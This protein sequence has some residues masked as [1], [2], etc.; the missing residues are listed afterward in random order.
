MNTRTLPYSLFRLGLVCFWLT[1]LLFPQTTFA[2]TYPAPCN[3]IFYV[4]ANATGANN[5]SS[6]ADAYTSLQDALAVACSGAQIWVAAGTYKPTADPS[7]NT[8]PADPRTKTFVMKNGVAI[9]GGF[10]NSGTPVMANRN[11][12]ANP[13]ILSGD[14]GNSGVDTDNSYR[15]INNTFTSG[16]PLDNTAILDGVIV[17]KGYAD[18]NFPLAL[19][20]GMWN[21]YASPKVQNCVFRNNFAVA[22]GGMFNDNSSST[23]AGCLFFNNTCTASGAGISNGGGTALVKILNCTF[24]GNTG[25]VTIAN[26]RSETSIINSIIWGNSGGIS[27]GL[28]SYS[29]VQGGFFGMNNTNVDPRFVN[30]AGG[31]FRLQ[32]YSPAIDA[33]IDTDAPTTDLTGNVRPFNATGINKADMGAYEYQS[34]Y[35][36]CA[37][38]DNTT[39]EVLNISTSVPNRLANVSVWRAC[40]LSKVRITAKGAVGGP[41]GNSE[42]VPGGAGATMIGEFILLSGQILQAVAGASG[43]RECGGGG[44]GVQISG[45]N[46]LILA[47]AGGGGTFGGSVG[48]PGQIT[49]G[50]GNGGSGNINTGGG[51]GGFYSGGGGAYRDGSFSG[52]GGGFAATGGFY[53]VSGFFGGGGFG[54]GGSFYNGAGGGGGYDGGSGT[55]Y[56]TG[57]NGGGSYNIG[58]NQNN[59]AGAN[60]AGGQVIIEYLGTATLSATVTPTELT[61]TSPSQGSISIDLTGDLNGNTSGGVE[62]AIVS[63]NSFTGTPTFADVTADP[64]NV[65]SGTGTMTGTYTVRIRLKYNPDIFVDRNYSIGPRPCNCTFYVKE[66]A[67]GANNGSSWAD[68]Y[69]SLQDALA[70]ACSGAQIWVAK[71]TYKPDQGVGYTPGN[72]SHSFSMKN[73]VAIYGG[74][75]GNEAANYDLSLRNFTTNETLLSGDIDGTPDVVTGSGSTLSITGNDGNSYH[76]ISNV[77]NQLINGVIL[78]GFTVTGGNATQTGTPNGLGFSGGGMLNRADGAGKTCNITINNCTFRGNNALATGGG[79]Y[80]KLANGGTMYLQLNKCTIKQNTAQNSGGG[81]ANSSNLDINR[82]TISENRVFSFGGGMANDNGGT[83][84]IAY[85][86]IDGN[87]SGSL[88]GGISFQSLTAG[89]IPASNITHSTISNNVSKFGAGL[90]SQGT[91]LSMTNCLVIGNTS[92]GSDPTGGAGG[93]EN[94]AYINNATATLINCSFQNNKHTSGSDPTGDDIYS[95]NFGGVQ[96]T[97]NLKNTIINGSTTTSTPNARVYTDGAIAAMGKIVSQGNNLDSDGTSGF[98]NGVNGD[99]V[100]VNPLFVSATD[101][102]LQACSPAINAGDPST[103]SAT[104]GNVDLG[105]N[106]RFY[107]NER[108]DMGAYEYQSTPPAAITPTVSSSNPTTCGGVEGSITLSGFLA[109]TIYSVTYKKNNVAISAANFTSNSSGVITLTGLGVGSYTDIVATYGVCVSNAVTATLEDPAKPSLTLGTIPAICASSTTFSIP[110]NNP[111]DSPNKYTIT[112][113]GITTVSDGDLTSPITVQL[114]GPS[115]GSLISFT[116]TV[117][118]STTTCVSNSIQGSVTVDPVSA[119]GSIAGSAT[120]CSGTNSTT[121][122]LSGQVGAIQKWQSSLSSD[123]S[124]AVDIA[125]TTTELTASNLTQTTYYRAIVKNGVCSEAIS[126][127][128]TVTVDPVSAGGSIAGSAT[129]CSGTNSTT[130]TLSGQVGAIQKWQSSLSSDFSGAVDIA[131]TTTE[132]TASNLTQTTYYRA[133]VKS[134]VCSQANST[135][136][137]VTVDPV[138][139]GGSISGSVTVCSG[140]NSTVLTLSGQVGAIQKWQSSLSSDFSGAVDISN[141]TTELTASNLTQPTYYRAIVKSGVC[142]EAFSS[143]AMVTVDPVSVGGSIAGLATV[144]SGANSTTLTLSGHVG[145][146]QKWQSSLSSDFSGALDIANTTTELIAS[147]LTQTTYYRAIVKSGVCS[148]AISMTARIQVQMKPTITLTTLQ[149]TL[150]EGN[151]QTFCDTDA[152]PINGLQFTVSGLCVVGNPVWRVQVGSNGWSA[153]SPNAPVSQLSNNQSHRYQAACDASC[154]VTYTSPIELTINYRASTPQNV[155]L[156]AD[157]VGVAVGETKEVCNIEG[158]AITFNATCGLGEI[159]LYSVDGAE[160]SSTLPVQLVDG[161]YHNYRVRCRKSDGTVSCVETE[162]GVMRLRI[163]SSSLVAPVASLNVTSGCGSPVSFSGTANCGALTTIWYNALTNVALSSLPNQTPTETS[164]YYARCQAGGGC[165]SEKSNVV[166]YTVI[167]LGVAPAVTVSQEIVC[168][169]TTVR[170]SANCPAGS[171]TFWNTGVTASSF[172]VSFSNVTKQSYWA[173]CLFEGGCQ[174]AESVRKDVYW[175]AF[176]V[177]LINIGESKSA[178]KVNNRS[179]WTSQF[180]T[181]DGG[182][183]LEQSTQINPT[184]YYVENTNKMAPRYWTINVDACAL[185]TNGS[186]TFDM[187]ATPEMGV[188]RSFNT[189]ENNAPYFMYANR[190]GWTEL[191]AQNHPAYGFYQDNGAG[192]NVYDA[193]LPKGLYKL[194]I[195]YW[196]QKGWGSIYPSTRK[197][198][199][200]VLA[201]QE[202]WFRIQSKDGVGVGAAREGANGKEQEAK[203]KWQGANGQGSDNGKQITDNGAFAT[204]LPNPVTHTLRLNV[205]D[206][207]GQVVQ[208]TLTDAAGRDVLSR[209]F[210]PETNTH[211]EEFGVSALPTG[212]YFLKVSTAEKQ[213]TLKVVKVE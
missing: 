178:V 79:I 96:S 7:G 188:L 193:G 180:I 93:L 147:N 125:N 195:R 110:Y 182:P 58:S 11:V 104:V 186:L 25:S 48:K 183:E 52:G 196:D 117:K 12:L 138:S 16:S 67:S 174:S 113:M 192:A 92:S 157:G 200:N 40:G 168:T 97:V 89:V 31:D 198:Q 84:N 151:A 194:G 176:V 39:G 139:V 14:I 61:C 184:L 133:I 145:T 123:F 91:N 41:G 159:L 15:V 45:G 99:L 62:Y 154:P 153:W 107:N 49:T 115:S 82:C 127:S 118:N 130:L 63:G 24:Y 100:N 208:T 150:N 83:L 146:I 46:L 64:F 191:Y 66:N 50:S 29:I 158:N 30:A 44:S 71:G 75:A 10:P 155:S 2:K 121:L 119:G 26:E 19:G 27:N 126:S 189:H 205:Q 165:L 173:K 122:T 187:L 112:G 51:G 87:F 69:T 65:T 135:S 103:T 4:K 185:G 95:G 86:V 209:Q 167:P 124:G 109:N 206:S 72:R 111:T 21:S 140:T 78:S 152:N 74:F 161:Q 94:V 166:T 13:T 18:G 73:G 163:V 197:A 88:G 134:G 131:N 129:V 190:E 60:N 35:D 38:Y 137:T 132:L 177:T 59:T 148:Q 170:I 22:G 1:V 162:S 37:T 6:W 3:N 160:Y 85:S 81:I 8:S 141:T 55:S 156:V 142:S 47:G 149:Q 128:A 108:I 105:G 116:L 175:N 164:S 212:M 106:S 181:R 32:Q 17:E 43:A 76:V 34:T 28:V 101:A 201:Y 136:V 53:S 144:C 179:A 213:A 120:V 77:N 33:G 98:T 204:V 202:Y 54:A 70:V 172:E 199:G 211:Q 20:G 114:N 90:H 57:A 171:Q 56:G 203:S 23:V 36:F 102:R 42:E 210:V 169:G 5:G 68:A 9:Y 80:S 143:S 207:K